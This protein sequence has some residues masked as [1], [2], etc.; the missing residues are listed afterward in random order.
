MEPRTD[1]RH[2]L[3]AGRVMRCYAPRPRNVD[4]M[5]RASFDAAGN[6][7]ALVDGTLRLEYAALEA[8]AAALALPP[9]PRHKEP[10]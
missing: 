10:R 3:H 9:L 5:L 4:A 6:A 2:E 8:R 1:M 7:P